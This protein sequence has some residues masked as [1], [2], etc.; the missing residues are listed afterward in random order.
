[1]QGLWWD[2]KSGGGGKLHHEY[3]NLP[4]HR[5]LIKAQ[6]RCLIKRMQGN[7]IDQPSELGIL[8]S[9]KKIFNKFQKGIMYKKVGG[10]AMTLRSP[11]IGGPVKPENAIYAMVSKDLLPKIHKIY[12]WHQTMNIQV[13]FIK[14]KLATYGPKSPVWCSCKIASIISINTIYRLSYSLSR[15]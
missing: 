12:F 8:K 7:F 13:K 11:V 14:L 2:Q 15:A 5:G 9:I 1:M 6:N 4:Q 10:G 3:M